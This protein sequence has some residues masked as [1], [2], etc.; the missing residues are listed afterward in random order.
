VASS[1]AG[2]RD[3]RGDERRTG[4]RGV[5]V[6]VAFWWLTTGVLLV[7]Q[8]STAT[9]VVALVVAS[10]LAIVGAEWIRQ[11]RCDLTASGVTRSFFGGA[12][13]W[14]WVATL[15][16]GGWVVG[17]S[18]GEIAEGI[19]RAALAGRAIAATLFNDLLGLATLGVAGVLTRGGGNRAGAWS[20]LT[21]WCSHQLAKLNVFAGVANPGTEFL[22]PYLHHLERY[23]GPPSNSALLP[24]SVVLLLATALGFGFSAARETVMWRRRQAIL[25]ASLIGLAALEHMLLGVTLSGTLWDVFLSHARG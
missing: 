4:L 5:F 10:M 16:Y 24:I 13:L 11:S 12:L 7:A 17:V 8:R 6:V 14:F 22:P 9:R 21:F 1:T 2:R 25:L 23:F 15:L 20:I 3:Q 18:G 19:S